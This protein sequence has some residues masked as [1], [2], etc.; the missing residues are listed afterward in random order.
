MG[1]G[2]LEISRPSHPSFMTHRNDAVGP[3]ARSGVGYRGDIRSSPTML[4]R[5]VA[6]GKAQRAPG[7]RKSNH[8][9]TLRFAAGHSGPL[10]MAHHFSLDRLV[11]WVEPRASPTDPNSWWGSPEARPT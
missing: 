8:R 3:L 4:N 9:G 7:R 6:G 1:R 11:G 2:F 10:E 5:W